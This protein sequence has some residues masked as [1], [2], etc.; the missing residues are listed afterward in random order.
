MAWRLDWT[1]RS[2]G[3]KEMFK[4]VN[5]SQHILDLPEGQRS[6]I[7]SDR[8]STMKSKLLGQTLERIHMLRYF[9]RPSSPTDNPFIEPFF[10]TLKGHPTYPGRFENFEAARSYC[11][12][13]FPWY[14]HRHL[15]LLLPRLHRFQVH[16]RHRWFQGRTGTLVY[17][18]HG[19][20]SPFSLY[21]W[22]QWDD[23]KKSLT[24]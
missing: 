7:V 18:T 17:S 2:P 8:G 1:V 13:F 3:A 15:I 20:T 6:R 11:L 23:P 19:S 22:H 14:S 5:D 16:P 9:T 21:R 12:S 4:E 10:S 24:H